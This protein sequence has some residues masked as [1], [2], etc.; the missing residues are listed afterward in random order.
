M[1]GETCLAVNVDSTGDVMAALV[2]SVTD[3]TRTEFAKAA[4]SLRTDD[5][6]GRIVVYFPGFKFVETNQTELSQ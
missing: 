1:D 3:D 6:C 5:S 4:R 2:E